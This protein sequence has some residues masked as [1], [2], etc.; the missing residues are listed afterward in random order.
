MDFSYMKYISK[1]RSSLMRIKTKSETSETYK[2]SNKSGFLILHLHKNNGIYNECV[3]I[4]EFYYE[5][6]REKYS[7]FPYVYNLCPKAACIICEIEDFV[8]DNSVK[9]CDGA[10]LLSNNAVMFYCHYKTGI[11]YFYDKNNYF[12]IMPDTIYN[13]A[14]RLPYFNI[15]EAA[16][17]FN[18][19]ELSKTIE[20]IVISLEDM[21]LSSLKDEDYFNYY[22]SLCEKSLTRLVARYIKSQF[23]FDEVSE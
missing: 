22:S 12:Y 2:H 20:N 16:S 9:F 18:K 7:A 10:T 21:I 15:I 14:I 23:Y 1:I 13:I 5:N 3:T 17:P 4:N 19:L 8:H 6:H 11:K